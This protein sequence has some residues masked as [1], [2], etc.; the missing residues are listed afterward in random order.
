MTTKDTTTRLPVRTTIAGH[1][2]EELRR[3]PDRSVDCVI[4]SP[5]YFL[6]RAY[7]AGESELGTEPNVDAYV[8][9]LVAVLD[10]VGR[11]LAPTGTLFLNIAD[12]FSRGDRYGAPAKSLLL[13][14]ERLLLALSRRGWVV[15]NRICWAKPNPMPSSVADR[16]S[17]TWEFLYLLTR[18]RSYFFDLDIVRRPHRSQRTPRPQRTT[19]KYGGT[20]P[21]WAGPL[22]G[23]NDGLERIR[24]EGRPGHPL[25]ANPGDVWTIATAGYRGAH[26]AVFP[27]D[28]VRRPLLAGCPERVCRR[29][30]LPWERELRRD[31]LGD[32]APPC[33]CD[34]GWRP[35]I[36][37]DPYMGSGTVAIAAEQH[38]RDWVG[39]ELN[40]AFVNL[41]W[42]RIHHARTKSS[43]KRGEQHRTQQATNQSVGRRAPRRTRRLHRRPN[44]PRPRQ[45]D[46]RGVGQPHRQP[47][48]HPPNTHP[49]TGHRSRRGR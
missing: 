38:D 3:L 30:G 44:P 6:L 8:H 24:A 34:A 5:P 40:P 1:A 15:R 33:E 2:L 7:G 21:V 19:A 28:L 23:A 9:H 25:G 39:I 18:S 10:E 16:F 11:V 42:T 12:S 35:G 37:L 14:P 4:T 47:R 20:R 29:C 41:A 32:I 31:H 43:T 46:R 45:Q 22:A 13:A 26:F 49:S 27:V 48:H 36:V 17:T